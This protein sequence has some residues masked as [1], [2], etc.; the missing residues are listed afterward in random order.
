[1][2]GHAAPTHRATIT[3]TVARTQIA[4]GFFQ[5]L[6]SFSQ[7]FHIDLPEDIAALIGYFQF[8]TFDWTDLAYPAGCINGWENTLL[9]ITSLSPLTVAACVL[10]VVWAMECKLCRA[11]QIRTS[12][13]PITPNDSGSR[14]STAVN[15]TPSTSARK[16]VAAV[17]LSLLIVFICLPSV[18]RA[19]FSTWVCE[20]YEVAPGGEVVSFLLKD[21]T[22]ECSSHTHNVSMAV[23]VAMLLLWPVGMFVLFFFILFFNRKDLRAGVPRSTSGKAAHFLTSGFRDKFFYWELV[24]LLRRLLVTGWLLLIPFQEMFTRLVFALLVSVLFLTLTAVARPWSR[25]EDN[26]LA[27]VSQCALVVAFGAC[28]VIKIVNV[29][30]AVYKE[31]DALIG[32]PSLAAPFFVLCLVALGFLFVLI[33]MLMATAHRVFSSLA[34]K[35]ASSREDDGALS[36]KFTSAAFSIGACLLGLP[37]GALG[38]YAFGILGGVIGAAALGSL[39]AVTGV[40][41]G[42]KMRRYAQ[43]A[44]HK[45]H[46]LRYKEVIDELLQLEIELQ[47]VFDDVFNSERKPK[48][49]WSARSKRLGSQLMRVQSVGM[50]QSDNDYAG[51]HV[52][53]HLES[54]RRLV[55]REE[56]V[57]LLTM[58]ATRIREPSYS[59]S[60]F[61]V[62]MVKCFP[63]LQ[64]YLGGNEPAADTVEASAAILKNKG[65]FPV[66][67]G[68]LGSES[69]SASSGRTGHVEYCRTFGALFCVYWLMRLELDEVD[70]SEGLGGQSGFCFG[71]NEDTWEA[72]PLRLPKQA[73]RPPESTGAVAPSTEESKKRAFLLSHNWLQLH[74]LMVDA[75]LL[76]HTEG[77]GAVVCIER[78]RAML[79]LTAYAAHSLNSCRD[80]SFYACSCAT[81]CAVATESTT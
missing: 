22:V 49:F 65:A 69:S 6:V 79:A 76:T 11:N 60:D 51:K 3:P 9:L 12:V 29:P 23:A 17:C 19:I 57:D 48:Y 31:L 2:F 41:V 74:T 58:A 59:I 64:L 5:V 75:G 44:M 30:G 77:G 40:A 42:T 10:F 68:T 34:K 38:G 27:L 61:H 21:P 35:Q 8:L 4:L 46:L 81:V 70:G 16:Q 50:S 13:V 56:A 14:S 72:T 1:M 20:Q 52:R 28:L 54:I 66:S 26:V 73:S 39:G 36:L 62:D 45:L 7:T 15:S 53:K 37:A 32:L 67:A 24:E 43:R 55:S 25:T 80:L 78:T 33:A 47:D 63:E 18:S 71:V